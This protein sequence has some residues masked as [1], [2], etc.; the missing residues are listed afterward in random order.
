[1]TN[2]KISIQNRVAPYTVQRI[3]HKGRAHLKVPCVMILE[4]VHC[5]PKGCFL[6]RQEALALNVS[7]WNGMPV[8]IQHPI[9]TERCDNPITHNE[10]VTGEVFNAR[11]DGNKL[12]ADLFLDE[13]RLMELN[14]NLHNQV[15]QG[16]AIEVSTGLIAM[17]M[18]NGGTWS[19]Q[20]YDGEVLNLKPD[21][22]AIL[23]GD[24]GACS[25]EDGCGIRNV[26]NPAFDGI[27]DTSWQNVDKSLGAYI[28]GYFKHTG[29][30]KPEGG[31][32]TSARDLP[33]TIKRWIARKTLNGNARAN[34]TNSLISFPVV[35]PGTNKLNKAALVSAKGRATQQDRPD[36]SNKADSLLKS[37]F[38]V[39]R[40]E[41]E[42]M[43][44]AK[45]KQERLDNFLSNIHDAD[46][47]KRIE[48]V[49]RHL[50]SLDTP[51]NSHWIDWIDMD[52]VIY[53][54]S[55]D[56]SK[57]FFRANYTINE[58]GSV[59][60]GDPVEVMKEIKYKVVSNE[61]V[62]NQIDKTNKNKGD[63]TMEKEKIVDGLINCDCT[64]WTE[65]ERAELMEMEEAL[66]NKIGAVKPV[67]EPVTPP[68]ETPTEPETVENEGVEDIKP[69]TMTE[70]MNSAPKEIKEVLVSG[71]SLLANQRKDLIAKILEAPGNVFINEQLIG[72][73]VED[74]EGIV[75]LVENAKP[76]EMENPD[77]P[78]GFYGANLGI[79]S[80]EKEDDEILETP[81][82]ENQ[83][84]DV[85]EG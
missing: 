53:A 35:N 79:V 6:Y 16:N 80:N 70:F 34:D 10:Q 32:P 62:N 56:G 82:F 52:K 48:L 26:N 19:G 14:S 47:R 71:L 3:Q 49:Q 43:E 8:S 18:A 67:E 72:K 15:L 55:G 36:I 85:K 61:N 30:D 57:N 1:M 13:T 75:A 4:G 59:T 2:N 31:I 11:M 40:N 66:L 77:D 74:L 68:V 27:E 5:N 83:F 51:N 76:K 37:R 29:A 21:H 17:Q 64:Q 65:N 50:D 12:K 81:T 24:V 38:E 84:G 7:D 73:S 58:D 22:L 69:V 20:D 44:D 54:I 28:A 63:N 78:T 42:N 39:G 9:N 46:L 41:G 25:I 45:D 33:D 60:L 23:P